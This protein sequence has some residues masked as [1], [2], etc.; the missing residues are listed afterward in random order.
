MAEVN[1]GKGYSVF[2][3]VLYLRHFT[4]SVAE[5]CSGI[6]AQCT[7][8][9]TETVSFWTLY[10]WGKC[11]TIWCKSKNWIHLH[12][13]DH[14]NF[15]RTICR[16]GV[17]SWSSLAFC[18]TYL[19]I[20]FG[21]IMLWVWKLY[22]TSQILTTFEA[23]LVP[24]VSTCNFF[25]CRIHGLLTF[26]T[27]CGLWRL[28]RHFWLVFVKDR[29]SPARNS[30]T[31]FTERECGLRKREKLTEHQLRSRNMLLGS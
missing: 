13:C 26:W 27:F 8:T 14:G 7:C 28:E 4:L 6:H 23:P 3:I 22:Q 24:L 10:L 30:N 15:C 21:V 16:H 20:W 18:C 17:R 5:L 19:R 9:A 11:T 12:I 2:W 31:K 1:F 29:K 25:F